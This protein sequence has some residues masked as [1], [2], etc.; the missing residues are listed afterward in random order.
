MRTVLLNLPSNERVFRRYMCS[1]NSPNSLFPPIELMALA[2]IAKRMKNAET[3]LIDAVAENIDLQQVI[4]RLRQF[5]P[6]LLVSLTGFEVFQQD[7]EAL[8]A[9]KSAFPDAKV[10]C[11][12]HYPT[13]FPKETLKNSD[14]DFILLNEP[15]IAFSEFYDC[16]QKNKSYSNLKGLAFRAKNKITINAQ[17]E[18]IKDLDSLPIPAHELL[19]LEK[20]SEVLMDRPFT[21]LQTSRGCPFACNYC[22]HTYGR[23]FAERSA[24][25][26]LE[27]IEFIA[28]LGIRSFRFFDDTFNANKR[29]IID[30]CRGIVERK[31]KMKW[32]C[33]SRV[34]TIDKEVFEWMKK[35]GCVRVLI[36]IESGS[37][38]IL[39]FYK[40]G[41]KTENLREK[42]KI[43]KDSGIESTGFFMVAPQESEEDFKKSIELAKSLDLD[44][45]LVSS[46]I[47]YPGTELFEGMKKQVEFSLFPY[48]NKF[49]DS[50]IDGRLIR[51]EKEFYRAFYFRPSYALHAIKYFASKPVES[52]SNAFKLAAY[53]IS[54]PAEK[55]RQ[56]F[57]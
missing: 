32:S 47:P 10:G 4:A 57:Y 53:V 21:V 13:L 35:A 40:K 42:I 26:V 18:R 28:G 9:L 8:S 38:R 55:T 17:R 54:K 56:D 15:D 44:F 30:V 52:I 12:G 1:Y 29:R 11:F 45:V 51:R 7:M 36:G 39:D 50:T 23:Q 19:N 37:Q 5:N 6:E 20:Y 2:G 22:V 31:I 49:V 48:E 34:D 14:I 24:E 16:L 3:L 41:Y 43:V 33:F 25:K 46:L 27:E